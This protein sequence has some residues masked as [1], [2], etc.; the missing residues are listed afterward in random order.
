MVQNLN[1]FTRCVSP[2]REANPEPR[3]SGFFDA[4]AALHEPHTTAHAT[5]SRAAL[6]TQE[7]GMTEHCAV[8][9]QPMVRH[10]GYLACPTCDLLRLDDA[11]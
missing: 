8:C 7:D 3:R 11:R 10:H 4:S 2:R 1:Q 6:I 5:G 9:D